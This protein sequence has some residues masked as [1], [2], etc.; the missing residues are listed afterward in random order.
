MKSILG[1][2]IVQLLLVQS[3][4]ADTLS[5]CGWRGTRNLRCYEETNGTLNF[6]PDEENYWTGGVEELERVTGRKFVS[7][8][9]SGVLIEMTYE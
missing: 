7:P 6:Q 5:P 3:A 9:D 4:I 1:W 2:L 8:Y